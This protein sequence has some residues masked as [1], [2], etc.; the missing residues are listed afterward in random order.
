MLIV[1]SAPSGAGKTT[2]CREIRKIIPDLKYSISYTTRPPRPG[3]EN[4]KDFF[5]V[6]KEEFN[7]MIERNEFAEWAVVHGNLYGSSAKIINGTMDSGYDILL[8]ID[9]QGAK[10]LKRKYPDGVFIFILAPSMKELRERLE[11][12]K[13]DSPQE[14]ERRM[15]NAREEVK[16]YKEYNYLIINNDLKEAVNNLA[17]IILGERCRTFLLILRLPDYELD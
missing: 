12:R 7:K 4:G 6:S 8:D 2:L 13:S 15:K 5:F 17:H 14:I 10:Q 1:L 3:E 9:T 11:E 16:N